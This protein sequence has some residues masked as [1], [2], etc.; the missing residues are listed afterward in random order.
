MCIQEIHIFI[1][2]TVSY[3][4]QKWQWRHL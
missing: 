4:D 3:I 2:V 1:E